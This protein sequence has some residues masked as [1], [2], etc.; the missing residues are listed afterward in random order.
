MYF[1][2]KGKRTFPISHTFTIKTYTFIFRK[3]K[4]YFLNPTHFYLCKLYKYPF[5]NIQVTPSIPKHLAFS[6]EDSIH[7]TIYTNTFSNNHTHIFSIYIYFNPFSLFKLKYK[8]H[9]TFHLSNLQKSLIKLYTYFHYLTYKHF[10]FH[11]N[12]HF[13]KLLQYIPISIHLSSLIH[14]HTLALQNIHTFQ[15]KHEFHFS[16]TNTIFT[17]N[18]HNFHLYTNS[19]SPTFESIIMLNTIQRKI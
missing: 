9:F 12:I 2:F 16:K 14:M 7:F 3:P 4:I 8:T 15:N 18:T 6:H 1:Y 17:F 19:A 11:L 10:I 5:Q 13:N